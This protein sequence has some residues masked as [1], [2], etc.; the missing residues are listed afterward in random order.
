M[1]KTYLLNVLSV[2]LVLLSDASVHADCVSPIESTGLNSDLKLSAIVLAMEQDD[3][4][5][6]VVLVSGALVHSSGYFTI[7]STTS[8]VSLETEL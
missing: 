6:C 1:G 2:G 7:E 4:P 3:D 5:V 8:Q